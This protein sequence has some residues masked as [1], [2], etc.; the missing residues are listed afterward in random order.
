[1]QKVSLKCDANATALQHGKQNLNLDSVQLPITLEKSVDEGR[2]WR[3]IK[4][5]SALR[6]LKKE[7]RR[8][9]AVNVLI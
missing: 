8:K 2:L 3:K 7:K 5:C 4:I 1:V 6:N 9:K